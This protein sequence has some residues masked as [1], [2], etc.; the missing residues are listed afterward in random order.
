MLEIVVWILSL[1]R[2]QDW[3]IGLVFIREVVAKVLTTKC[4]GKN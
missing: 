1:E 4:R 3:R 2:D